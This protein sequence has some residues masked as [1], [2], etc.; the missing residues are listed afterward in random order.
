MP[1]EQNLRYTLYQWELMDYFAH[2]IGSSL[3][4]IPLAE[5]LDQLESSNGDKM[6]RERDVYDAL[7][8]MVHCYTFLEPDMNEM[9]KDY[10]VAYEVDMT[11]AKY[12]RSELRAL[13]FKNHGIPPRKRN[14]SKFYWALAYLNTRSYGFNTFGLR[15]PLNDDSLYAIR[16]FL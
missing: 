9:L 5:L 12:T 13:V 8:A 11:L 6:L 2:T 14:N 10:V 4:E 3:A 1:T 7:S 16:E 15:S